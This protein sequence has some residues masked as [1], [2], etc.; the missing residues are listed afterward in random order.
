MADGAPFIEDLDLS[1]VHIPEVAKPNVNNSVTWT[2]K[3]HLNK[4]TSNSPIGQMSFWGQVLYVITPGK[5]KTAQTHPD[6]NRNCDIIIEPMHRGFISQCELMDQKALEHAIKYKDVYWEG[7]ELTDKQVAK[8]HRKL[9]VPTKDGDKLVFRT[10]LRPP[11]RKNKKGELV[12]NPRATVMVR[13]VNDEDADEPTS[14]DEVHPT[15]ATRDYVQNVCDFIS[16]YRSDAYFGINVMVPQGWHKTIEYAS[17]KRNR[18][19]RAKRPS[20]EM[21]TTDEPTDQTTH[22]GGSTGQGNSS[23]SP[24]KRANLDKDVQGGSDDIQDD[25]GDLG[26]YDDYE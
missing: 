20:Q 14:I 1:G 9:I 15:T 26:D 7:Q 2:T 3:V 16:F 8:R 10:K 6:G 11:V 18:G 5:D 4:D 12:K 23:P 17:F 21:E 13:V 24:Q 22:A 19:R 25:V